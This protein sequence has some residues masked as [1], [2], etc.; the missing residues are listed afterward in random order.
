VCGAVELLAVTSQSLFQ[1]EPP[2]RLDAAVYM[3]LRCF[4]RFW[5][6]GSVKLSRVR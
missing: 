4:I 6:A 1:A 5:S 3:H 2:R